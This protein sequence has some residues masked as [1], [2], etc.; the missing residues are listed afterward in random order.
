[1][2]IDGG[3]TGLDPGLAIAALTALA[4]GA[5]VGLERER[6]ESGGRFA[7]SRTLP[8][9]AV[10]GA[11]IREFFPDLLVV[12]AGLVGILVVLGYVSKVAHEGDIGLTTA[13]ATIMV[14][15][16]GAMTTHSPEGYTLAVVLGVLT[17][18]ILAVKDPIHAFAN[19]L[20]QEDLRATLTFLIVALVVLPLLPDRDVD[21]LVGLNPRF[22]WLMVVFVSGI[23]LFAYVLSQVIGAERGIGVLGVLGGF[24][25]STAT[26]VSMA[27]RARTSPGLWAIC[28]FA[29][30]AASTAMFPRALAEVAVVHPPLV[31]DLAV[32][33]AAM[34]LVGGAVSLGILWR[35]Y[36]ESEPDL[37]LS[38]PF[39]LQPALL[40]G[41]L[42]AVILLVS[43]HVSVE[44]GSAGIYATAFVSGLADVD[45]IAI[46]LARLAGEGAITETVATTGIV[47]AAVANTLVK[48]G[49]AWAF[50][51]RQLGK[52]V[53]AGLLATG[54][55]GLGLVV[56]L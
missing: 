10:L 33:M 42:F 7:G 37:E 26:T 18:A 43:E 5:L 4:I 51:T 21:F 53:L 50:G 28:G 44:Y 22:V 35:Y 36:G 12:T 45:A 38:N 2:G 23:S 55:A 40:F 15:V 31:G 29:V 39:R 1:M 25:S 6:A 56:L 19:R 14:F 34:T 46:S 32:P 41:A 48:A 17:T 13:V 3:L 30:L 11:L 52:L 47:V 24:V 9:V 49:I 27:Q 8:L 20:E 16:Y 54:A